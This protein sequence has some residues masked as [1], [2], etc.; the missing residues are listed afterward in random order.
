MIDTK[1]TEYKEKLLSSGLFRRVSNTQYRLQECP[2]CGDHKWH[3]YVKIDLNSDTP[4]LYKCFKCNC[5]GIVNESFLEYIGLSDIKIPKFKFGKRIS[6]S[7]SVS[8]SIDMNALSVTESDDIIDVCNYINERVGHYPTLS[9]LQSFNYVGNPL[10]YVQ[11]YLGT[12]GQSVLK[13]RYWFRLSNGNITGRYHDDSTEM[14]WIRYKSSYIKT[15]GLYKINLPVDLYQPID[16]II[17]EGVID[18]IGLYYNHPSGIRNKV[19][20][21]VMGRDYNRAIKYMI[22]RGIYGTSV[23]IKIFKDSDVD[24][25][26]I[27]IDYNIKKLFKRVD[28]YENSLGK[29]FGVLPS[30]LDIARVN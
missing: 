7:E 18:I 14:R 13:N 30:E 16:V 8:S 24:M 9:E 29:D 4:V 22:D 25:D 20:I 28:I 10:K 6:V 27:R 3:C 21:G 11:D 17:A 2:K 5:S 15:N 12:E 23:S 26:D 19:Y 1:I